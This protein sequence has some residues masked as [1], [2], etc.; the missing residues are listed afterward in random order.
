MMRDATPDEDV[1]LSALAMRSK[2]HWGYDTAFMDACRT[3]LT[4][5]PTMIT[6]GE[7]RVAVDDKDEQV[8]GFYRL[9][10]ANG[11]A[12]VELLYVEPVAIGC[13]VGRVLWQDLCARAALAKA[14][15]VRIEADPNA[16]VFYE[17]MGA[18]RIGDCPS[19]SIPGRTLP[20]L[21]ASV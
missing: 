2:A 20:L 16:V 11:E 10:I 7:V 8:Q 18:V 14:T 4:V 3:E 13:G 6:T 21:R 12:N 19:G 5:T 15:T 9:A 1:A 17:R